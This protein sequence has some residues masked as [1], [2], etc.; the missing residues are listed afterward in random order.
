MAVPALVVLPAG[1]VTHVA[2]TF[3]PLLVGTSAAVVRLE[4][5]ELGVYEWDAELQVRA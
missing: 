2:A 1:A 5:P 4:S 3:Q